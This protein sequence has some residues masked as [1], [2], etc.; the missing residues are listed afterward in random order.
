MTK[1]EK[2]DLPAIKETEIKEIKYLSMKKNKKA[3]AYF[4][5]GL[6]YHFAATQP[7]HI[8]FTVSTETE[9]RETCDFRLTKLM[10]KDAREAQCEADKKA[11]KKTTEDEQKAKKK[12]ADRLLQGVLKSK[13]RSK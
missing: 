5:D 4:D 2:K 3:K 10:D 13:K 1:E 12:G 9:D 6:W 8:S 11:L 7:K